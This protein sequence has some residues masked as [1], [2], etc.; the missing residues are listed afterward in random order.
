MDRIRIAI[1]KK[2]QTK[3]LNLTIMG[4]NI[5]I[6]ALHALQLLIILYLPIVLL[7]PES[8]VFKL[9]VIHISISYRLFRETRRRYLNDMS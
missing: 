9:H 5:F 7:S 3:P 8:E 4:Y 1:K 6:R 2:K